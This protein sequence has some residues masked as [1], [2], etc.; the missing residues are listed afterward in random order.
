MSNCYNCSFIPELK[1]QGT[2][3]FYEKGEGLFPLLENKIKNLTSI[4]KSHELL[5]CSYQ[6]LEQL[7]KIVDTLHDEF[8]EDNLA[9]LYGTWARESDQLEEV[10]YF[11]RMSPFSQLYS[12]IKNNSYFTI[13]NKG[14]FT[15]HIQPII[16]LQSSSLF[17]YEFLLRPNSE[18]A[19]FSPG[20]LFHFSQESGLQSLLD[21]QARMKSIE[22]GSK[23]LEKGTKRFI[24]F[25]PSS[26]YD[27]NHCLKSTF[28]AVEKYNVEPED[29]IFEVVE[30]EK[31]KDITHLKKIFQA[32]QKHGINVALDDLGAGYATLDVLRKLKPNYAKIDRALIDYC[33]TDELKQKKIADIIQIANEYNIVLLAEG[34]ERK[35]EL[36]YCKEQGIDLAQGYYIGKPQPKPVTD[37]G[38]LI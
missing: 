3:I 20:P 13:I 14:L 32:Y 12:R 21:S 1:E 33:D 35:E 5:I 29:L 10:T 28:T 23:L 30:T 4:R 38:H 6:S 18:D 34:I 37:L 11:P 24:N 31:I 8:V 19:F 26:I 9:S 36:L 2:I 15:Q 22:V 17:G 27:P 25:L 7:T 16:S